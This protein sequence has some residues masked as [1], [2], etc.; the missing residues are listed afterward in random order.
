MRHTPSIAPCVA[1]AALAAACAGFHPLALQDTSVLERAQSATRGDLTVTVAVPTIE[2]ARGLFDAKLHKKHIQP[3]WIEIDNAGDAP[4]WFL[5]SGVDRNYFPPLEAAWKSHRTCAKKTNRRIDAYFYDSKV[6]SPVPPRERVSGFVFVNLDRGHKY[7]PVTLL[8]DGVH[9]FEFIVDVPGLRADH[10]AVDFRNLYDHGEIVDLDSEDELRDWVEALPCCTTNHKGGVSGDP[11]N[12]V[13]VASDTA[14]VAGF[15]RAGWDET[16]ALSG[17]TAMKTAGAAVFGGSYRNAPMSPLYVRGRAQDLG[18]QKA[19]S[20]IHQRNHL[21][22]WLAPATYRGAALWIGQISR[23]IGSR[24]TTK[25][26]TFTTHKIDPDVDDARDSLL[27]D[28]AWA[29]SLA[30]F[31]FTP[32]VGA[33]TPDSPRKNLT[34]DPYFTDGRRVVLF[35]SE[36][37]VAMS[38]VRYLEQ[39]AAVEPER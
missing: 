23:D 26:S 29:E 39:W 27:V 35:L 8:Q 10:A 32:G 4:A 20:N 1:A 19:R 12:F 21:R 31:G 33:A 5:P 2:E 16:V 37:P 30:A 13:L 34:G 11:L 18:L 22:L 7:V 36:T 3:I 9:E 25:S 24:L 17:S 38:E 15:V 14:F 28:L 6:P